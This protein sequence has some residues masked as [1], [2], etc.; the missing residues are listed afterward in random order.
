MTIPWDVELTKAVKPTYPLSWT[1]RNPPS[2]SRQAS[3]RLMN[4]NLLW[5][6]YGSPGLFKIGAKL[7]IT[8]N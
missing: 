4:Y 5:P 8:S 1:R 2:L 3:L 6:L 7:T